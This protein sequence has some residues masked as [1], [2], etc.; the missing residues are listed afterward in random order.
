VRTREDEC[1]G[2]RV[3]PLAVEFEDGVASQHDEEL[4][5]CRGVALV[6]LVDYQV[7]GGM[8]VHTVAPN[9][10]MPRWCRTGR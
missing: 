3:H 7:V 4:L 6:V 10:A 9:D 1:P 2:R 5:V 8:A